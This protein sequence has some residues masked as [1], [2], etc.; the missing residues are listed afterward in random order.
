M[1]VDALRRRARCAAARENTAVEAG[2]TS[3]ATDATIVKAYETTE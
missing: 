1:F 3:E 2:L